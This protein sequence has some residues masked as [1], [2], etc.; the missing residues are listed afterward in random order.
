MSTNIYRQKCV[1]GKESKNAR[2][3]TVRRCL[4]KTSGTLPFEEMIYTININ[5]IST[6]SE[7]PS[8]AMYWGQI[9]HVMEGP[10]DMSTVVFC[11]TWYCRR[12][13]KLINLISLSSSLY[14]CLC[15]FFYYTGFFFY[16]FVCWCFYLLSTWRCW[17]IMVLVDNQILYSIRYSSDRKATFLTEVLHGQKYIRSKNISFIIPL[18]RIIQLHK[19]RYCLYLS[20]HQCHSLQ[21]NIHKYIH[22]KNVFLCRYMLMWLAGVTSCRS[23][24]QFISIKFTSC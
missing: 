12:Y 18:N 1:T 2:N 11:S 22:D 14:W 21:P 10:G 4:C 8:F 20:E 13:N 24:N 7:I 17:V 19:Y 6:R 23:S 16:C 5:M 9:C 3:P 15:L